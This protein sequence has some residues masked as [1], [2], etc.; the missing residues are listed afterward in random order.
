VILLSC[1]FFSPAIPAVLL[2]SCTFFCP[3][4]PTV[5]LLSCTFFSPA[6]PTVLLQQESCYPAYSLFLQSLQCSSSP[7]KSLVLQSL[8]CSC[9]PAHSLVLHSHCSCLTPAYSLVL[10]SLQC[11][12]YPA[13][14]LFLQSLQC[15]CS[16]AHYLVLQSIQCIQGTAH[17]WFQNYLSGRSQKVD[18]SGTFSEPLNLDILV[19]QG[20]ILG[21]I[22][23]LCYIND[24][25]LAS[26]LLSVLFADDAACLGKG[27][28]LNELTTYVNQELNK[29]ANWFRANKM[30][31]NTAKTKFIVFRTRGKIINPV[32]CRLVYNG[33]EIGQPEDPSMIYDIERIIMTVKQ[34]TLNCW[35]SL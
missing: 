27:K 20:S 25:W 1:T 4:I 15:S 9:S 34:R 29:I 26:S 16:P 8:Q 6:I 31:V 28:I 17:S 19:I 22:L 33:N 5:F 7:A 30:A 32:D 10:Q 2:L 35:E 12:C 18:I 23:F 3:A 13:Y 14:S 24:F 11:S 21:P